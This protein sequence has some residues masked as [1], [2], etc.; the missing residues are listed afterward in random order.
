[1]DTLI[2]LSR[3]TLKKQGILLLPLIHFFTVQKQIVML[4]M[5]FQ[6]KLERQMLQIIEKY[7][8][9]EHSTVEYEIYNGL[10]K[11]FTLAHKQ[12]KYL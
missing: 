6:L 9:M 3:S 10:K 2:L 1:M 5:F 4:M 11:Q 12:Q 8:E 7:F